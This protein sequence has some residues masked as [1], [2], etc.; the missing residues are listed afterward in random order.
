MVCYFGMP[1]ISKNNTPA[2]DATQIPSQTTQVNRYT[3]PIPG[4]LI[5]TQQVTLLPLWKQVLQHLVTITLASNLATA[6]TMG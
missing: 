6:N 5:S 1:S 2:K 3:S 4:Y